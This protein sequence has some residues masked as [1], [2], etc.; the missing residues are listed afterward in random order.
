MRYPFSGRPAQKGSCP[1]AAGFSSASGHG[2]QCTAAFGLPTED[3][4]AG[5]PAAVAF[6]GDRNPPNLHSFIPGC[7]RISYA[8]GQ[9][10][11]HAHKKSRIAPAFL[12]RS[13]FSAH[14]IVFISW[15]L[16]AR[17]LRGMS[18]GLPPGR[19]ARR[20]PRQDARRDPSPAPARRL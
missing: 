5:S 13:V 19:G 16:P 4:A 7:P 17:R 15:L 11:F 2:R 8:S 1:P 10:V 12:L 3:S 18:S 6:L 14:R 20:S 9:P